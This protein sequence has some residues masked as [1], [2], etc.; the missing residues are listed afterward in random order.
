MKSRR[1]PCPSLP[2]HCRI[3]SLGASKHLEA[4]ASAVRLNP[5]NA[6]STKRLALAV[7]SAVIHPQHLAVLTSRYWGPKGVRLSVGFMDN[8]G[9]ALSKRILEHMNSWG[10]WAN[11]RFVASDV[12]PQV[13]IA[14]VSGDGHWSYLGTDVLHIDANAATMNLDGFT[15]NTPDSEFY[16]VVRHETG[17][18][19][20]FPHEHTRSEIVNRIDP[21]KAEAYYGGS[22]NFWSPAQV[23]S[24]VLTPIDSSALI[25]TTDA[26]PESIMCYWLPASVMKD[27][28]AVVGGSDIDEID[29]KFAAS[30]YPIPPSAVTAAS[31]L[32][33]MSNHDDKHSAPARRSGGDDELQEMVRCTAREMLMEAVADEAASWHEPTAPRLSRGM[34]T[35]QPT[36]RFDGP[37]QP[38]SDELEILNRA[39]AQMAHFVTASHR[40]KNANLLGA[41]FRMAAPAAAPAGSPE[42][43]DLDKILNNAVDLPGTTSIAT[44]PKQP[45][46]DNLQML[47]QVQTLDSY[48]SLLTAFS[49]YNEHPEPYDITD[50]K[51]AAAF[52]KANAKWRNYVIT[53]GTVKAM[54]GYLPVG[55][56]VSQSYTKSV[57]SADLHLEF[58]GE[59]F[60]DFS[61]PQAALTQL[62]G[63]LTKVVAKLGHVSL[64]F[65][66]QSDTLDHFLTYY[67]F[68]TV[69]GTG[70]ENGPPAMY[71]PKVRTF[72][73]HIDQSSWKAAVGKSSVSKFKFDMSFYD[74]TTTMNTGLV[75]K[76]M[77]VINSTIEKL[78][79]NTAAEVKTLMNMQ[80]IK[81]DPQEA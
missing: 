68:S 4:A 31:P 46:N 73:L 7:P 66:K 77:D 28:V 14:R 36:S 11:V 81:A 34:N 64:S 12:D 62:D 65:E 58:L 75:A 9:A 26:D 80:A 41:H 1:D 37:P 30:V 35:W 40:E 6:P 76:D 27:N 5:T 16:R 51:Q 69:P 15:M 32:S 50:P 13:R 72:Y 2:H 24:Q 33:S 67:Y 59:L 18:T 20:G 3:K 60:K 21:K 39:S 44:V 71:V 57:T 42:T 78:S 19:L 43:T 23:Q 48:I 74:M 49:I 10:Q 54:A 8:P 47:S 52:T 25:A 29:K 22:P 53:G 55:S 61:F 56:I 70:G 45:N 63:I 17:H 38:N 79:G